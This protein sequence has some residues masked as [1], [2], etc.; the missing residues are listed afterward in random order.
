MRQRDVGSGKMESSLPAA[1]VYSRS[2]IL[3]PFLAVSSM[4]LRS[5]RELAI[6][7]SLVTSLFDCVARGVALVSLDVSNNTLHSAV[8][9]SRERASIRLF[10][11]STAAIPITFT[12]FAPRRVSRILLSVY[13]HATLVWRRRGA[14]SRARCRL[15]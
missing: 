11:P 12:V 10:E 13:H 1:T 7:Q 3:R 5:R 4:E 14:Q 2:C 6:A 8:W 9:I 15:A